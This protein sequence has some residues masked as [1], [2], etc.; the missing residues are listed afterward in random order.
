MVDSIIDDELGS[1][2]DVLFPGMSRIGQE[3]LD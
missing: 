3:A 1:H 2:R